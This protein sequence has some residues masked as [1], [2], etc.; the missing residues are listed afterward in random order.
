MISGLAVH[1]R[2][3]E[4]DP[5]ASL[6]IFE[7]EA[8]ADPTGAARVTLI[9]EVQVVPD[10][11]RPH[12]RAA[13]VAMA[14]LPGRPLLYNGQ[15]VES[16]QKLRL[17][18]KDPVAWNQPRAAQARVFYKRV[19]EVARTDS[20]FLT[21]ELRPVETSVPNDVIAYRRGNTVVLVNTRPRAAKFTV[22]SVV[23]DG[24]R[25]L[26]SGRGQQGDTVRLAPYAAIVLRRNP[27]K[28]N[29]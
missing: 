8:Q 24:A 16:P 2:N 27:P 17:F 11:D 7:D 10:A 1:H 21:G 20:A 15:E 25:D 14:L 12:A 23:V 9:G 3:L 5:R 13:Y 18:Y 28:P 22:S 6:T 29:P 26:L 19:I 4:A